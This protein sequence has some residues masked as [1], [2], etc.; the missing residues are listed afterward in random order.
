LVNGEGAGGY[1]TGACV[2][3]GGKDADPQRKREAEVA[4]V[5]G[6]PVLGLTG[7][8][9]DSRVRMMVSDEGDRD[10]LMRWSL[11]ADDRGSVFAGEVDIRRG[12]R[13]RRP[14]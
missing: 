10:A 9:D 12:P 7:G 11:E 2:V 14:S 1:G 6:V 8:D 4:E 3:A 5:D 13:R